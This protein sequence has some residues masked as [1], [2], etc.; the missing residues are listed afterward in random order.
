MPQF[1]GH[2]NCGTTIPIRCPLLGHLLQRSNDR[3]LSDS[4]AAL[5]FSNGL[6]SIKCS[7][8]VLS[9][10]QCRC[11]QTL[12]PLRGVH[13]SKQR[14]RVAFVNF[15]GGVK[16]TRAITRRLMPAFRV[17]DRPNKGPHCSRSRPRQFATTAQLPTAQLPTAQPHNPQPRAFGAALALPGHAVAWVSG[18]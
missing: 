18:F 9:F 12:S 2:R 11:A 14:F 17:A 5:C 10:G 8:I 16:V 3:S 1:R 4:C 15:V 6:T 7:A 13:S